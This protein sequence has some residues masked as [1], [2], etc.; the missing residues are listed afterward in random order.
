MER[1]ILSKVINIEKEIQ[2]KV[3]TEKKKSLGWIETVRREIEVEVMREEEILK[4]SFK[5]AEENAMDD[6]RKEASEIIKNATEE[7][8]RLA[9]IIDETLKKVIMKHIIRILPTMS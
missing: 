3:D 2:E 6:A 5:R 4:E 9:K 7:S 8:K 1:D